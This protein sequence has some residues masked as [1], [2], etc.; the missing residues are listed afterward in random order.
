MLWPNSHADEAGT[1]AARE[2]C[3]FQQPQGPGES[4]ICDDLA[5]NCGLYP[6]REPGWDFPAAL[7]F[8]EMIGAEGAFPEWSCQYV[9]GSHSVLD[10]K[11]D[12]D[13]S[14]PETWRAPH[15]RC[16]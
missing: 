5:E 7:Y 1:Q 12:P 9:G 2:S 10:S 15:P 3:S 11:V 13:T 14:Q 16:K 4:P 8:R 6:L